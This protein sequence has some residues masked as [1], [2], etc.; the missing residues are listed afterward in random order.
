MLHR[1]SL[2]DPGFPNIKIN[3]IDNGTNPEH[4]N[5]HTDVRGAQQTL[6]PEIHM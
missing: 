3:E 4:V 5:I 6:L 2:S 1:L